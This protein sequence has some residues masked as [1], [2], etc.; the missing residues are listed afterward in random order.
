MTQP[1]LEAAAAEVGPFESDIPSSISSSSSSSHRTS[2]FTGVPFCRR[3]T[4]ASEMT[5]S[6]SAFILQQALRL[7]SVLEREAAGAEEKRGR[8]GLLESRVHLSPSSLFILLVCFFPRLQHPPSPSP[9][10]PPPPHHFF[11][12]FNTLSLCPL[13]ISHPPPPP[14][15]PLSPPPFS[16][17]PF[18]SQGRRD[19]ACCSLALPA[20]LHF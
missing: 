17:P 7:F 5:E 11:P 4:E 3:E 9:P 16:P 10:P 2:R 20:N 8:D 15:P 13:S 12:I 6:E 18:A 14:P 19:S 1:H